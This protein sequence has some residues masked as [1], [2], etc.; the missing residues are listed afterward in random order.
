VITG[1]DGQEAALKAGKKPS[2]N[3]WGNSAYVSTAT[4]TRNDRQETIAVASGNYPYFYRTMAAAIAGESG[5]PVA[6]RQALDVM[7]IIELAQRSAGEGRT[8]AL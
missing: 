1:L 5:V 2:G 7:R 3:D 6:P 8:V 4:L